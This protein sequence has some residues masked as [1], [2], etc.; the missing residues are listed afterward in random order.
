MNTGRACVVSPSGSKYV[1]TKNLR[2]VLDQHLS[3]RHVSM[4]GQVREDTMDIANSVGTNLGAIGAHEDR[5][6]IH[7]VANSAT[8]KSIAGRRSTPNAFILG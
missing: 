1:H 8:P 6:P 7:A 4:D 5:P 2:C 3:E